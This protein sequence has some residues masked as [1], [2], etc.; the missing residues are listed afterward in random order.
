MTSMPKEIVSPDV[1]D[2]FEDNEIVNL[3]KI[4]INAN[5]D[6]FVSYEEELKSYGYPEKEIPE[7]LYK[8]ADQY[9]LQ[10]LALFKSNNITKP[11]TTF[12]M[13]ICHVEENIKKQHPFIII[14]KRRMDENIQLLAIFREGEPDAK[15]T[16]AEQLKLRGFM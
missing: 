7:F 4:W 14:I 11:A 5:A 15:A 16:A 10:V 1:F 3:F 8:S 6:D 2:P 12:W 9:I 13:V